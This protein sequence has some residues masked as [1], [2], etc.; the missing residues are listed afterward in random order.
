MSPKLG[1]PIA[2]MAHNRVTSNLLMLM[3][4]VAGI[5]GL[6]SVKQEIFPAFD[7]DMVLVS[8]PYP[9][10]SPDEVEQGIVL[11]VEE[12]VRG[13]DGVKRVKASAGESVGIVQVEL[14]ISANPEKV[15]G[16]VKN[17]IDRIT[18]FPEDAE[19]PQVTL[20]A[21]RS[22]VISLVI[23][24]DVD[25]DTLHLLAER[26]RSDI[27]ES[28]DVTQIEI[29]GVPDLEVSV[30][31]PRQTLESYG[32]TLD[33]VA[34]VITMSS[35]ELPGGS[36]KTDSGEV[37]VR[38][39]DR[40]RSG[41]ELADVVVLS[42]PSGG[43][44]R[45]GDIADIKDGFAEVDQASYFDGEPAVRLTAYRI[46]DETPQAVA[47]A[48]R[49]HGDALK[50][51]L[52]S[53][54]GVEIW[55]DD[56]VL[57]AQRIDLLVR[58]A[59]LGGVLVLGVLALFLNLRLAF[60]VA[61]G[62]PISFFGAFGLLPA[63]DVS[64]N[65]ISLFAL[66]ITLGLV[67][68]DAIIIGE[69]IYAKLEQ[70][71]GQLE[72]AITGAREM[73]VPVTFAI[74]TSVAA[75]AP[76]YFVPGVFGKI[77]RVM[78]IVVVLVLGWSLIEAFFIL[79]AHL[80]HGPLNWRG[81][82]FDFIDRHQERFAA[83]FQ[84]FTDNI[85]HRQLVFALKNRYAV[86]AS[87]VALLLLSAGLLGGGIVPFSIFPKI[88]GDV[89]SASARLPYGVPV[90][91]TEDVLG[92][93]EASA[94]AAIAELQAE[95]A[96]RGQ[97]STVGEI[98]S[99]GGHDG[100]IS[101]TGS[102]LLSYQIQFV[103]SGE[104]E[105][106]VSEFQERWQKL[107]PEMAGLEVLSFTSDI[108][109]AAQNAAIDVQLSH[110]DTA[111]IAQASATLTEQ[112]RT[113]SDLTQVENG[114]A[115]GKDQLDFELR[116]EARALGLST[117][118]VARQL[119][120]SFYGSE[121][122][123]EQRDRNELKVMVRLPKDQRGSEHDVE[124]LQ[125]RTPMGG[126]VPL[127]YVAE[128][129]RTRAPTSIERESGRRIVDVTADLAPGVPSSTPVLAKLEEST[130]P[131]LRAAYPGLSTELVGQE[132]EAN[133][134]LAAL[135]RGYI[136][137]L[138]AIYALLAIPFKSYAQPAIV[139]SAIPFGF[140][141]ALLGHLIM[142]YELSLISIFGII[143]LSGVVVND[144]LVLIDAANVRRRQHGDSH[145][146]AILWAGKRRL[147]PILLTS[148]TTFFGLAPMIVETEVQA[149]FLVPMAISLGFGV[150]FGTA[151]I[152]VLVPALY[153]SLQDWLGLIGKLKR[154]VL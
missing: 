7:L 117:T 33:D 18:T 3:V 57:L 65:M 109:P 19:E 147:R 55:D 153:M 21:T 137:A 50:A 47:E 104:R 148:L 154:Q 125:V 16:D 88:E 85:F 63:A 91:V 15:L 6:T 37:L 41:A 129:E 151:V 81:G 98:T 20:A 10:A 113:Y 80:G 39:S 86:M 52:P 38:V 150:L 82:V 79:P 95:G 34:R 152:L 23:H 77:F 9:G 92:Q 99:D 66:I 27:L 17:E 143:A 122:L 115:S 141:G 26:S 13:V 84:S 93:L 75:F 35:L 29:E 68:D 144:S 107:T 1:G 40:K 32:L 127:A 133:E 30:E 8:V 14:L 4:F 61:L 101:E 114:Y 49:A 44:V 149:R 71:M 97:L 130:L 134:S 103:S 112:L 94:A 12:A 138:F 90:A 43:L 51:S 140:V 108:G 123:R 131:A 24:G 45:L 145:Y 25:L 28:P 105:F 56:S 120:A 11:A 64:I 96:V 135:G 83:S 78:P 121:A 124:R 59:R 128:F 132:R 69:N 142:G 67:V 72:A 46:G 42:D 118:D 89:V 70:G 54:I 48:V 73:A 102:H 106:S 76:M 110:A 74:L 36:V 136:I 146:E 58:N 2:W 53:T 100:A 139:M 60:W 31:V 87:A 126:Y 116:P 5:V 111:V 62:I 22:R 119:R